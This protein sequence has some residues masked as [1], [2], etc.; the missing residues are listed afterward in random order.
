M[1]QTRTHFKSSALK[2]D[3]I[4]N[5]SFMVQGMSLKLFN[6]DHKPASLIVVGA[7]LFSFLCAGCEKVDGTITSSYKAPGKNDFMKTEI[8]NGANGVADGTTEMLIAIHLKNSDNSSVAAYQPTYSVVSGLGVMVR[9][10]STSDN[11][12]I[13][14]CILTST[15][16]GTK[17]IRLTNALVGLEKNLIFETKIKAGHILG[18]VSGS[19]QNLSTSRSYKVEASAGDFAK[20]IK[21][22]TPRGYDVMFSAQGAFVSR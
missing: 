1:Y 7:V 18:L 19:R 4:V 8:I 6:R 22:D 10:C 21:S 3:E 5:K 20:G 15:K 13:S 14:A 17:T 16:A 2:P 9:N 11:N 12:G